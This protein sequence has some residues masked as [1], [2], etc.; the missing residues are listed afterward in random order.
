MKRFS[1]E[2]IGAYLAVAT[3]AVNILLFLAPKNASQKDIQFIYSVINGVRAEIFLGA[4]FGITLWKWKWLRPKILQVYSLPRNQVGIAIC[5][6]AFLAINYRQ[7]YQIVKYRIRTYNADNFYKR[8]LFASITESVNDGEYIMANRFLERASEDFPEQASVLQP[9]GTM[10]KNL[11]SSADRISVSLSDEVYESDITQ[12]TP[13]QITKLQLA[14]IKSPNNERRSAIE[15]AIRKVER[16]MQYANEFYTATFRG[17]ER[18][19]LS[20][21]NKYHWFFFERKLNEI[22]QSKSNRFQQIKFLLEKHSKERF[23]L[24]IRSFWSVDIMK[25]LVNWHPN[26]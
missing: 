17:D 10:L 4:I 6:V 5:I 12:I 20:L 14:Y 2:K 7:I 22:V 13:E 9:L 23:V 25:E 21:Y 26:F 3:V 19:A 24:N 18:E 15:K 11:S 16:T 1:V 8:E